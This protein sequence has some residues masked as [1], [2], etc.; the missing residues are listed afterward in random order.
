MPKQSILIFSTMLIVF[1]LTLMGGGGSYMFYISPGMSADKYI[2]AG[3]F[4]TGT[5]IA[6]SGLGG[7]LAGLMGVMSAVIVRAAEAAQAKEELD[8]AEAVS[9]NTS[10]QE[11]A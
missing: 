2:Q 11:I 4:W 3:V 6:L 5:V 10:E 9:T 1:S 8:A 7:F